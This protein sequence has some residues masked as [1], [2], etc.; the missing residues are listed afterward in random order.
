[1]KKGELALLEWLERRQASDPERVP[2]DIGDDMA[3]VKLG[4]DAVLISSDMLLDGVHFDSDAHSP[5]Q[6]GRKAVACGLSDCAAM[7]VVPVCAVTSVALPREWSD[8]QAKRLF[9]AMAA[10]GDEFDCPIVGGDITSWANPLAIDVAVMA[11][12][13]AGRPP[14]RR[15]GARQGDAI[16]VTGK[17]GASI[18]GRHLA[19]TPRV[20]ES[21]LVAANLGSNLHA[22]IDISDGLALDLWRICEA[23]GCGAELEYKALLDVASDEAGSRPD[24]ALEH[25]LHDGEDFELLMAVAGRPDNIVLE[26]GLTRIG[27]IIDSGLA[28]RRP[29]GLTKPVEPRGYEHF[30]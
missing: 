13:Q 19:F 22:M 18:A 16:Y 11:Q 4:G 29:N 24:E 26:C 20:R 7:A 30:R 23:S 9:E 10:I 14:I 6:V 15:S 28:L 3:A 5:E 21:L 2:L 25:V 8:E 17:L 1:M 27:R 12:Q